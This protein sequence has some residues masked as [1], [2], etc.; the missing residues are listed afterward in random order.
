VLLAAV[1]IPV[2]VVAVVTVALLVAGPGA[3]DPDQVERDVAAE[4]EEREGVTLDL[5][6]PDDLPPES[7]GVYTCEGTTA[8]G[9]AVAVE[10]R[11][12]DPE[13]DVDYVWEVIPAG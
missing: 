8:D 10:I 3:L 5:A 1:G 2:V 4:F 13:D 12:A 7:G 6:C 9:A 11:I